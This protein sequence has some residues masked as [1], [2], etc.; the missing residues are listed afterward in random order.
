MK[1]YRLFQAW[2]NQDKEYTDFLT[3]TIENVVKIEL[4]K[5]INIEVI[6]FPAQDEAG[7]PDVVNMVWEQIS[8]CDLFVGD[9][10]SIADNDTHSISNPNV[11]YEV[12]IAD[13]ILGEKRVILV[14]SKE[15][16][17]EK[18]AFDVNHKRISPLNKKIIKLL[19][20]WLNG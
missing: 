15:T 2:Q 17:I 11:M 13:A 20:F 4:E 3:K 9:L 1:H 16:N 18:L 10:T 12:G 19:N 7:S 14:C 8:N 5:D 6:R